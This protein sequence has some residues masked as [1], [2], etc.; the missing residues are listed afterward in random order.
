M[1]S[2]RRRYQLNDPELNRRIEDLIEQAQRAYGSSSHTDL[3]RQIIVSALQFVRDGTSRGDVR[4][5]NS[6]LKELRHAF[7]TFAPYSKVRKVAVFGSARTQPDHPDWKAAEDFAERIVRQGWM[8]I[9]GAGGGIMAA[10]QGGAGRKRSFGVNI[11]LPFEQLANDV[12]ANDHKL[13]NF[14]YFFTRKVTFVKE[15]HA[16]VLFPGGFGTHDEGFET[17]TL[18]QTGKSEIVPVVY[19]DE[20]GGS[21]WADWQAYVKS[22]LQSRGLISDEDLA[23]FKVTDDVSV[24]VE[25]LRTFYRNYHSSRWV[26]NQLLIRLIQAPDGDE[27]EQLNADFGDILTGGRINVTDALP[28]EGDAVAGHP[29]LALHF[30]RRNMGRLRMLID[31]LNTIEIPDVVPIEAEPHELVEQVLSP[32][33]EDEEQDENELPKSS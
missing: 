7:R 18:M 8:V 2:R 9:T 33:A 24:A 16:V 30:N 29:R 28:E 20:P 15:S 1:R 10:A 19:M 27:I 13:I 26:G 17:L 4:L 21:Y 22:H 14:R 31:R 5:I 3:I 6:A 32:Q 12:I 11:R 23:L 25:E